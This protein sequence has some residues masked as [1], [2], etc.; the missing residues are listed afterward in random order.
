MNVQ[1][2]H[3]Q[4]IKQIIIDLNHM[5]LDDD[6]DDLLIFYKKNFHFRTCLYLLLSQY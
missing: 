3:K 5:S 2:P 1:R 4:T 6:D